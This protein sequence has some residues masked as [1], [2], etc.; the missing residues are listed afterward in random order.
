MANNS[1]FPFGKGPRKVTEWL[2]LYQGANGYRHYCLQAEECLANLALSMPDHRALADG[3]KPAATAARLETLA[4]EHDGIFMKVR[5][6]NW[7]G[8]CVTRA[9]D[10]VTMPLCQMPVV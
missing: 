9:F 3:E 8:T 5:G 6:F 2:G 7:K 4:A 1:S 10:A